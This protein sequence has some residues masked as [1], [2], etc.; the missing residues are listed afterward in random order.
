VIKYKRNVAAGVHF[1]LGEYKEL[2]AE[3]REEQLAPA[4]QAA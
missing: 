2:L 3:G 4:H 1:D